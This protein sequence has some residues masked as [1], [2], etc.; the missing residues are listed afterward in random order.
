MSVMIN[1]NMVS[2]YV[3]PAWEVTCC[4][5][6]CLFW[7]WEEVDMYELYIDSVWDLL[8]IETTLLSPPIQG[9]DWIPF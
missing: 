1:V 2:T 4:R 3:K 7:R 6:R 8:L 5:I 9:V